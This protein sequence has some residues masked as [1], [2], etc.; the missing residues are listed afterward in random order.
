MSTESLKENSSKNINIDDKQDKTLTP[1]R[2]NI[3]VLKK[4]IYEKEKKEKLHGRLFILG[5][6]IF[7]CAIGFIVSA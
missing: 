6:C 1:G 2:V 3:D 4:K 7:I 5:F